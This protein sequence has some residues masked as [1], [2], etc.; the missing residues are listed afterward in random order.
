VLLA[1]SA[2]AAILFGAVTPVRA[3]TA[4]AAE[5]ASAATS[6]PGR[7]GARSS[8]SGVDHGANSAGELNVAMLVMVIG[9]GLAISGLFLHRAPIA[10]ECRIRRFR[11]Q[12]RSADPV[13][14]CRPRTAT[15]QDQPEL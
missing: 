11:G 5:T 14:L 7:Y 4:L 8:S 10:R 9:L 1:L 15:H 2:S 12:L 6:S 13:N 3:A